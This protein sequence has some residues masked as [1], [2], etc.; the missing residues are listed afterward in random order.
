MPNLQVQGMVF[1]M[2][3]IS[4]WGTKYLQILQGQGICLLYTV[5]M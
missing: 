2:T 4:F 5:Q 1:V 3:I